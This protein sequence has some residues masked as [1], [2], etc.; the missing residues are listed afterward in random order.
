MSAELKMNNLLGLDNAP[1]AVASSV[2]LYVAQITSTMNPLL[3]LFLTFLFGKGLD[4]LCRY[5]VR[6]YMTA[7]Q[8]RVASEINEWKRRAL[9]AEAL[10]AAKGE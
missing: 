4:I 3:A 8:A 10:L 2:A 9:E 6:A 5:I 7:K 1:V